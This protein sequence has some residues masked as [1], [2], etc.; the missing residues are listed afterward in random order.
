MGVDP[1]GLETGPGSELGVLQTA[2]ANGVAVSRVNIMAMNYDPPGGDM[3]GYAIDA[4]TATHGQLMSLYPGLSSD[5]AWSMLGVTT[6]P[7]IND[8]PIPNQPGLHAR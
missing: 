8:A 1:T 3:G 7:G 6:L 2:Q 5:Q 4:A